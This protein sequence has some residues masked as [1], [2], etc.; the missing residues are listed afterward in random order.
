MAVTLQYKVLWSLKI[1]NQKNHHSTDT[2]KVTAKR[3]L[4]SKKL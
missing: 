2:Y 1:G 4:L 3:S